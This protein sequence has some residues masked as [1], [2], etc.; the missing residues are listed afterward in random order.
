VIVPCSPEIYDWL[1]NGPTGYRA[2]YYSADSAGEAF[3][4]AIVSK[5]VSEVVKSAAWAAFNASIRNA[6]LPSLSGQWAKIGL[7]DC[8]FRN[9][10]ERELLSRAWAENC[11]PDAMGLRAPRY[12]K[13]EIV[14]AWLNPITKTFWN[15]PDKADRSQEIHRRG[16]A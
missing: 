14:G 3:N 10:P 8:A 16:Y 4:T 7:N 12:S 15:S 2:H 1:F 11:K 6:G 13:V 9:A 5:L